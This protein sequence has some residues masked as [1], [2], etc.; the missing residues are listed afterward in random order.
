M[1]TFDV[2]RDFDYAKKISSG[3]IGGLFSGVFYCSNENVSKIVSNFDFSNNDCLVVTGSGDQPIYAI[4]EDAAS[5]DIFDISILAKYYLY[6]R[7]WF[8][9]YNHQF[10]PDRS[11]DFS[12]V[13]ALLEKV[14][15]NSIQ[16]AS[17]LSFWKSFVANKLSFDNLLSFPLAYKDNIITDIEK[18]NKFIN[19]QEYDS[20]SF[21]LCC[22][23][24]ES[25]MPQKLY[26]IIYVSNILEHCG[27]NKDK[28]RFASENL[29]KLLKSGG[30]VICSQL[31]TDNFD[32]P[33]LEQKQIFDENFEY[34]DIVTDY[35]DADGG[36]HDYYIGYTYTKK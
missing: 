20:F 13:S 30:I 36:H 7:K 10:Y 28:I 22:Q 16:E 33:R 15:C 3:E 35:V 27:M 21:D 17:A 34:G 11:F 29:V 23:N 32:L 26:D 25:L 4:S 8:I 31:F 24:D 9:K 14:E 2:E 6:L 1:K 5:V 19:F 12:L 18:L